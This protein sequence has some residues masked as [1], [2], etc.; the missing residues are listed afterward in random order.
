VS[1][2]RAQLLPPAPIDERRDLRSALGAGIEREPL[3]DAPEGEPKLVEPAL[4][5]LQ[6]L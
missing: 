2:V 4:V 1:T 6:R 3:V 5:H